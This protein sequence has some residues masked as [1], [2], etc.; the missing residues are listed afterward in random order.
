V[1][2]AYIVGKDL[3]RRGFDVPS[4]HLKGNTL[5]EVVYMGPPPGYACA[6]GTVW[7]LL[8]P[9]YGLRPRVHGHARCARSHGTCSAR[10]QTAR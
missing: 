9:L 4:A 3:K 5:E 7:R 1:F 6:P 2:N 10:M 8:R